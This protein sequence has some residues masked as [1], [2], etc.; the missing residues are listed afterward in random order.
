MPVTIDVSPISWN[1][2]LIVSNVSIKIPDEDYF[3]PFMFNVYLL[4]YL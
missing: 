2:I 4:V 3:I 1:A